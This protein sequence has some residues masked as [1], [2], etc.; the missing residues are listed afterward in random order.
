MLTHK[1][2]L[3]AP[4]GTPERLITAITYGADAVYLG[5]TSFGMRTAAATF[6]TAALTEGVQ[7][8]HAR[9]VRVY[10]TV[11]V[12]PHNGEIDRLPAFLSELQSIGVDGI[13]VG[14]IGVLQLAK[15]HAPQIPLHMSVQANITNYAAAKAWVALGATRLIMSREISLLEIKRIR[16]ELP[17]EIEI[18]A[19]VHGAMCLSYSGRCYLSSYMTGRDANHGAC[20]QPCRYKFALMEERRPGEYYPVYEDEDGAHILNAKDLR[21]I[22]HIPELVDAGVTAF[23]IEGRAKTSMYVSTVVRAYRSAIDTY[24]QHPE[25]YEVNPAWLSELDSMSHRVY[26]TGFYLGKPYEGQHVETSAYIQECVQV[27]IV[28]ASAPVLTLEQRNRF[29]VGDTLEA[30]TPDGTITTFVVTSMINGRGQPIQSA[31]H[32]Q[33][34]VQLPDAPTLPPQTI[35]RRRVTS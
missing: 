10:V 19:F 28:T 9:G 23:K 5:G 31:P 15:Q 17:P 3:L 25:T 33:M 20:A 7:Y 29:M 27:A 22:E 1:P 11:N 6:D 24:S 34:V 18:E 12:F 2:E 35:L 21:M 16:A 13:I 26:S 14:D 30:L 4:A 8:A 32:A